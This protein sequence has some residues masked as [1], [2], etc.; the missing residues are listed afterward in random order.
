[1]DTIKVAGRVI[2]TASTTNMQCVVCGFVQKPLDD[3]MRVVRIPRLS[4]EDWFLPVHNGCLA[5]SYSTFGS[6]VAIVL[7]ALDE[8]KF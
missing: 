2:G 6:I 4:A 1:M 3:G 7:G 5:T 8:S